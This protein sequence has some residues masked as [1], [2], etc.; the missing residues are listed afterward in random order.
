[1]NALL[2][3]QKNKIKEI[4]SRNSLIELYRFLFAMWVVWYHGYFVFKN[5]YFDDGYLA[6]EFFFMLSGFYYLKALKKYA[7]KPFAVGLVQMLWSKIK[8]LGIAFIV[9]VIF[10]F[11]QE[12]LDEGAALFGYLWYIP[13]MLLAFIIIYALHRLIKSKRL[14]ILAI[15]V[16]AVC[17]YLILYIP[18]VEKLGVARGLGAVS[19]GVL[20]S[21]IPKIELKVRKINF[22]L[23]LTALIFGAVAYLS[24][25][26]KDNLV[27]EY[28]LVFI[29]MPMLIYFTNTLKVNI[30]V[31][32]FL[33]SLSFPI[34]AYQCVLRVI[35]ML[36][37][38]PSYW[39]MVIL[40]CLVAA[41]VLIKLIYKRYKC[42]K[43]LA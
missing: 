15:T 8:P 39:L 2:E 23:I 9:G 37:E 38:I 28:L 3:K 18:L 33:G 6:V 20:L 1:M 40:L 30:K 41:D 11:W 25:L 19:L 5:E 32:N 27:C 16:I 7:E 22:N 24:F 36:H 13:I 43:I 42:K 14:F 21:Y 31:L 12:A 26:P 35:R 17:S 34:Y 4:T 29:L 10:V